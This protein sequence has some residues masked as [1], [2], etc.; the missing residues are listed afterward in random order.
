[1]KHTRQTQLWMLRV[2][3][4]PDGEGA[5]FAAAREEGLLPPGVTSMDDLVLPGLEMTAAERLH[6]YAYAYFARLLDIL[7][8]EYPVVCGLLGA[9]AR[10]VLKNF[11]VENPSTTY[12]LGGLSIGFPEWVAAREGG[13]AGALARVERAMEEVIDPPSEAPLPHAALTAIPMKEWADL[14]LRPTSSLMLFPLSHPVN[15][16]MNAV[17]RGEEPEVPEAAAEPLFGCVHRQGFTP[18]RREIDAV[19]HALLATLQ[20]GGTLGEALEAA[21]DVPGADPQDLLGS[22]G[23]WFEDWM[24]DGMFVALE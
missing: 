19:Q 7:E 14:R 15:A 24:G 8:A 17:K 2:V 4:H 20:D 5:G 6:V 9:R 11:L 18:W 13:F 1:M 22:L 3:T 16:W 23:G 12:T 21:L 10:G